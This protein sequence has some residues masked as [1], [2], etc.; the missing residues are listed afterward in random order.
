MKLEAK[1]G[2]SGGALDVDEFTL[3]WSALSRRVMAAVWAGCAWQWAVS[4]VV[5][6][7]AVGQWRG[8]MISII[9]KGPIHPTSSVPRVSQVHSA[10]TWRTR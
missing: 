1:A 9:G 5:S 7:K 10:V 3:E 2:Y 4:H 8:E 6:P